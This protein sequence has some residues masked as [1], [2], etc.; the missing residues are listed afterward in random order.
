MKII[1]PCITANKNQK[2]NMKGRKSAAVFGPRES[3]LDLIRQF[4]RVYE[5]EPKLASGLNSYILN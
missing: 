5:C 4:A 2:M 1:T 3:T